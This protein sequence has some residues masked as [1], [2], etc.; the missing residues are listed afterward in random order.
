MGPEG[1]NCGFSRFPASI[2]PRHGFR[3]S[4]VG[5]TVTFAPLATL[6]PGKTAVYTV[7]VKANAAKD[8]RFRVSMTSAQSPE[9]VE[10]SESTYLYE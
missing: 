4:A 5:K 1:L 6:A 9:P 7:T 3:G 2:E 8:V 10:E